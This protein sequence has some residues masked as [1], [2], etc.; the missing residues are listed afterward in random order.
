MSRYYH[1][2][3]QGLDIK[4]VPST[5][6]RKLWPFPYLTGDPISTRVSVNDAVSIIKQVKFTLRHEG[7]IEAESDWYPAQAQYNPIFYRISRS[8]QY[9]IVMQVVIPVKDNPFSEVM[10]TIKEKIATIHMVDNW[11]P[12]TNIFIIG[13]TA[14]VS[15]LGTLLV[16]LLT[17]HYP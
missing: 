7:E 5:L 6:G 14:L 3:A 17:H 15:V 10:P 16:I 11:K 1:I 12:L 9:D 8:G 4:T 2:Q 13:L